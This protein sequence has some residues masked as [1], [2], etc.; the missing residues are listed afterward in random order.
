MKILSSITT[1]ATIG[2]LLVCVNVILAEEGASGTITFEPIDTVESAGTDFPFAV[3]FSF[4]QPPVV[5][6]TATLHVKLSANRDIADTLIFRVRALP[7]EYVVIGAEQISWPTPQAG[8]PFEIDIP[9]TFLLGGNFYIAV[10]QY[11]PHEKIHSLYQLAVSFGIDGK[12]LSFGKY[13]SPISNC[14]GNFHTSNLDEI[15]IV[16]KNRFVGPSRRMG[17]PFDVELSIS[18]IPRIDSVSTVKL[19]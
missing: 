19:K 18:P 10:E 13:P 16:R 1:L 7:S 9:V 17:I 2:L 6:D 3:E 4:L 15:R 5:G 8:K 11:L 14:A 12:A